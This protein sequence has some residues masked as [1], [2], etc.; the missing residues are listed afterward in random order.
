R[1]VALDLDAGLTKE[2]AVEPD[3]EEEPLEDRLDD[4]L[5][6]RREPQSEDRSERALIEPRRPRHREVREHEQARRRVGKP[7]ADDVVGVRS[8]RRGLEE[9]GRAERVAVPLEKA[10][11][12][13]VEGDRDAWIRAEG[14]VLAEVARDHDLRIGARG[15]ADAETD[16]RAGRE[17]GRARAHAAAQHARRLVVKT[18]TNDRPGGEPE[19]VRAELADDVAG[20]DRPREERRVERCRR[21][22]LLRPLATVD[23]E[24]EG[25]RGDRMI[26]P[27]LETEGRGGEIAEAEELLRSR[28]DIGRLAP[29]PENLEKRVRRVEAV[30][31]DREHSLLIEPR[32]KRF[33]LL[34]SARLEADDR[35]RDGLVMRVDR[36]GSLAERADSQRADRVALL[37]REHRCATD[38]LADGRDH[39]PWIELEPSRLRAHE[40]VFAVRAA[41][42]LAV[43]TEENGLRSRRADIEPKYRHRSTRF[44]VR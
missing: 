43:L 1:S 9:I 21:E 27:G 2:L 14:R 17:H 28:E 24:R 35:V 42:D 12:G 39:R 26:R 44:A 7:F 31:R 22:D 25:A 37:A 5:S 16:R 23:V 38:D 15:E 20:S 18:T 29:S 36:N 40:I 13:E 32:A 33:E 4:L 19:I 3:L 8:A 6:R 11:A 34:L 30:A 41:D 10:A